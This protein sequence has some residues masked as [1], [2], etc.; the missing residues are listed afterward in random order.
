MVSIDS[1]GNISLFDVSRNAPENS[2]R[3]QAAKRSPP[4]ISAHFELLLGSF[5]WAVCDPGG[6]SFFIEPFP[7]SAGRSGP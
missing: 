1:G 7:R 4:F 5:G 2:E 3:Q 6:F